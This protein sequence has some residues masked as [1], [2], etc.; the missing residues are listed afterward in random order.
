MN[1]YGMLLLAD[2]GNQDI[3]SNF[4]C[5]VAK[6]NVEMYPKTVP[7][8]AM[9]KKLLSN[10]YKYKASSPVVVDG[11]SMGVRVLSTSI[12]TLFVLLTPLLGPW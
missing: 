11:E 12:S 8:T 5:F 1:V 2:Q 9:Q 6:T 7:D 10:M 4:L 3:S